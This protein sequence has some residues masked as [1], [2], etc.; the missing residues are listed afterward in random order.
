MVFARIA[1]KRQLTIPKQIRT[2]LDI[3]PGDVLY[4]EL[5]NDRLRLNKSPSA[6]ATDLCK[7]KIRQRYQVTLPVELCR[8]LQIGSADLIHFYCEN[9]D[10]IISRKIVFEAPRPR[11]EGGSLNPT[12]IETPAKLEAV[13][14]RGRRKKRKRASY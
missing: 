11:E 10:L 3:E 9:G 2:G 12:H 4:G 13:I 6:D 5:L 8:L 14:K 1:E 7:I